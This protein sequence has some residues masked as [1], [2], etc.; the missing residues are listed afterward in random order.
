VRAAPKAT[1]SR[2]NFR[3]WF[4]REERWIRD[5]CAKADVH[6]TRSAR[7]Q[8]SIGEAIIDLSQL[9]RALDHRSDEMAASTVNAWVERAIAAQRDVHYPSHVSHILPH[10]RPPADGETLPWYAP[11]AGG[12]LL[13]CLVANEDQTITYLDPI[14]IIKHG[15]GLEGLRTRARL[16]LS[17]LAPY[18]L[19]DCTPHPLHPDVWVCATG[20]GHDAARL[21][22]A[23]QL[24]GGPVIAWVPHR[25]RLVFTRR[26][27]NELGTTAWALREE[28]IRSAHTATHPITAE[29][30]QVDTGVVSHLRFIGQGHTGRLEVT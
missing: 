18:D 14:E 30:F 11:I 12:R 24:A 5:A 3:G 10:L 19:S 23:D 15:L 13:E 8:M 22:L 17:V 20:D 21:S 6:C 2:L 27:P 7:D 4:E 9:E 28:A 25:D 16:N 26:L 29:A 1:A